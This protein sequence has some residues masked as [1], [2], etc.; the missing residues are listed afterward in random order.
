MVRKHSRNDA[1]GLVEILPLAS[2]CWHS[3]TTWANAGRAKADSKVGPRHTVKRGIF[4]AG[5]SVRMYYAG[6]ARHALEYALMQPKGSG[7]SVQLVHVPHPPQAF[8]RICSR[9]GG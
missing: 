2:T 8:A 7:K 1:C 4:Q 3:K 6:A 9:A 5:Q